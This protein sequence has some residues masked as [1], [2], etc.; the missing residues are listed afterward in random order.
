MS[1]TLI[2]HMKLFDYRKRDNYPTCASIH[3]C[4]ARKL[5]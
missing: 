2:Y 3:L 5:H 1:Y 4:E